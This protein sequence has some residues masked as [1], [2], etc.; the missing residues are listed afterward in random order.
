LPGAVA[1]VCFE[2]GLAMARKAPAPVWI[3]IGIVAFAGSVI[4]KSSVDDQVKN[5]AEVYNQIEAQL[6]RC[7]HYLKKEESGGVTTVEQAWLNGAGDPIKVAVERIDSSGREL[8]EYLARDLSDP[9]A[10]FNY[11]GTFLLNRKET[12]LPDGGTQVDE[13]RKYFGESNG[14]NGQLLRELRKS[15]RFK[16]GES[17]D[18][19]HTPNVVV[20]L[21]KQPRDNRGEDDV[22]D[23][24]ET[25][26]DS[27][28]KAGP[29]ESD[30]FAN[31]KGDSEN[32]RVIHGTAS[33]D[34]RFAIA[35][36]LARKEIDWEGFVEKDYQKNGP[37]YYAEDEEDV[38]NYVVDLTRQ[39][40]LGETGC[41]YFGTR[42]RYNHRSCVVTWSPDSTKFVQLW[43][44]KWASQACVA[45]KIN[46]DKFVGAVDLDKAIEKKTY[47]FVKKRFE[48]EN[49]GSLALGIRKVSND[50]V[51]DLDASEECSSGDCKGDTIFAVREQL[52][53]RDTPNGLRLDIVNMRR[54]PNE[55]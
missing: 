1:F 18:T 10:G 14:G 34:G 33:P 4:A 30:P 53:L 26:V 51:I 50:G 40:I 47:A 45:G 9:Y 48:S 11:E 52:R 2:R 19:V 13:S 46:G 6:N 17:T 28:L 39:K 49:G 43:D 5:L 7:V 25:L 31:V 38:R 23:Q 15:A 3:A 41:N 54:L 35:L 22:F 27:L 20:A 12:K 29:P 24:P 55:Q 36:G 37:T 21:R 42:R 44:D 16:P 8:T 32:F